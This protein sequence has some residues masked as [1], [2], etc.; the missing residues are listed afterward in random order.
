[1]DRCAKVGLVLFLVSD[2]IQDGAC[3]SE[4][5][6]GNIGGLVAATVAA[7]FCLLAIVIMIMVAL[8]WR[9]WYMQRQLRKGRRRVP[10]RSTRKSFWRS[11][12]Q[13]SLTL[14]PQSQR[15]LKVRVVPTTGNKHTSGSGEQ[16]HADAWVTSLPPVV[17]TEEKI[18]TLQFEPEEEEAVI[19]AD[20]MPDQN[21]LRETRHLRSTTQPKHY[22]QDFLHATTK[23]EVTS[24]QPT[25][26]IITLTTASRETN[27]DMRTTYV[28]LGSERATHSYTNLGVTAPAVKSH[29]S[30]HVRATQI[31]QTAR[32][33][34]DQQ[35][36]IFISPLIPDTSRPQDADV[37]IFDSD[38]EAG[39]IPNIYGQK[40]DV[41]Y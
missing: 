9:D 29:E 5:G 14:T 20:I 10:R 27:P 24:S 28:P 33:T 26:Q 17:A 18:R 6:K 23:A 3:G 40:G 38:D 22:T 25:Q 1:M 4:D 15:K 11:Q 7:F 37:I 30:Y 8:L 12:S 19:V 13:H 2:F 35:S 36:D 32:P 16:M 34:S 39:N 21:N 41:L 31:S